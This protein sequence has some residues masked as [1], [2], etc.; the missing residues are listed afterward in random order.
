MIDLSR[1]RS[2]L[3]DVNDLVEE[4]D[5]LALDERDALTSQSKGELRQMKAQR[6]QELQLLATRLEL[7]ASL[8]RVEFWYA[9]GESDPLNPDREDADEPIS[10]D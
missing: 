1:V 10:G 7:A 2:V 3:K 9:R 4:L 5:G 8:T 6:S